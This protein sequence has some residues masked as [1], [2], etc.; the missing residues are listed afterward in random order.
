MNRMNRMNQSEIDEWCDENLPEIYHSAMFDFEEVADRVWEEFHA[1]IA[2]FENM[3]EDTVLDHLSETAHAWMKAHHELIIETSLEPV[4]E[5]QLQQLVLQRQ[6]PQH[7]T[8]WYAEKSE[9]LTASEIHDI[10]SGSRGALLRRKVALYRSKGS[11][12]S[13]DDNGISRSTV[14]VSQPDGNM[15]ATYWGHRFEPIIRRIYEEEKAGRDTV[16]DGLG[17]FRHAD[18]A[19][20]WL[21]ASPDGL[22]MRGPLAGR[23]V[24]IKAPKTRIPD[25]LVPSEYWI[26]MQMQAE[27]LN[28][29]AVEFVEGQFQQRHKSAMT[30]EDWITFTSAKWKGEL[31]V[32]NRA[33]SGWGLDNYPELEYIYSDP[34]RDASDLKPL[35]SDSNEGE[36]LEESCW[37][38][39]GFFP[40]TVLRDREW[41]E[42]VALP[43]AQ[44]FW[45]EYLEA[46][47][48]Q[49]VVVV[50]RI[51]WEGST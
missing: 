16:L 33:K 21:R 22:V 46:R 11:D 30:A 6:T 18:T 14:S 31:M 47:E 28:L 15:M 26:Q 24:E 37:W 39:T 7:A 12:A 49:E 29:D 17:R 3:L 38:L 51:G 45:A 23:L 10:F 9:C 35:S 19:F 34:V 20:E 41:W 32:V 25:D 13:V 4:A 43:Q 44:A 42:S 48:K 2:P 40:R 27:V 1:L 36:V 50:E 8:E 5:Q